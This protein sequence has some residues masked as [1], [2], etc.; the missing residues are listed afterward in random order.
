VRYCADR[1][2]LAPVFIED[3]ASGRTDW[4]DRPLGQLLTPAVM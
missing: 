4:R 2:L 3:T 1:A